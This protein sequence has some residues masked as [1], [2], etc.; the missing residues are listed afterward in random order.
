MKKIYLLLSLSF[1]LTDCSWIDRFS[2]VEKKDVVE[3][4]IPQAVKI[5]KNNLFTESLIVKNFYNA[6]NYFTVW[7][8]ETNRIQFLETILTL[9][10]EGVNVF[11]YDV[12]K[13]LFS[14]LHYDKLNIYERIQADF[15][16]TN[17]FVSV[18]KQ[19]VHGKVNPN[20]Y[21]SDWVAPQK[22]V[23]FN[24]VLLQCLSEESVAETI[25]NNIPNN[26]YYNSI[27]EAISFY[28]EL[29]EDTLLNLHYSDISKIKRKLNYFG[30][31]NFS[32]FSNYA[33]A[34]FVVALK[35]FQK[36]HGIA[37]TG[38]VTAETLEAL[39]VSKEYRLKQLR[40]NLERA[41]WFYN[42]FGEHYVLVNIPECKLFLYSNGELIETHE[43]IIGK[44]DRKTPIL[45]SVFSDI[46]INP[47]W[48][49][50]PTILKNDLVPKA[51]ANRGYFASN[52]I[53]IYNK[54]G[55]QVAPSDWDPSQYKNYRYVQKPGT[56]N[57]LGLIKFN[58]PNA[59]MVYLHDTSNRA[60]FN[61]KERVLSSGCVR[62]K[63]PFELAT[64]IFEIEGLDYDQVKLDTLVAKEKTKVIPLN[65]KVNVHQL[66]WTA[67][68]DDQG[69]QFRNDIYLLDEGLY[70]KLVK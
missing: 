15:A 22:D 46:V 36:R 14:N 18:L 41:R 70:K 53:T 54:S 24:Q 49:V 32:D 63:D 58:F 9:E 31:S 64:K 19:L 5:D 23:N 16:Y 4:K 40:V 48:T 44:Q 6:N 59:H 65:K 20:K 47:T 55:N 38:N 26:T 43:V 17:T 37:P 39:N 7:Q 27:K 42:E 30:D 67:W 57:A 28:N 25:K 34:D 66:Y 68:K 62:V 35:K 56:W 11:K 13:L 1:L 69:I 3:I 51:S 61:S 45:S 29:P 50:P 60:A 8:T 10:K 52:R 2:N 21:Y 12:S 33:D